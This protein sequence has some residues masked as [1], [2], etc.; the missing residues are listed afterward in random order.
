VV[1]KKE[2]MSGVSKTPKKDYSFDKTM[3]LKT[4]RFVASKHLVAFKRHSISPIF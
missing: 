1:K 3:V 4:T 2:V